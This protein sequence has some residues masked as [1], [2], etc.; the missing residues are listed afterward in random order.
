MKT[1]MWEKIIKMVTR[2]YAP[3]LIYSTLFVTFIVFLLIVIKID[4]YKIYECTTN[5]GGESFILSENVSIE[6][7]EYLCVYVNKSEEIIKINIDDI[8]ITN[9]TTLI[10]LGDDVKTF[11][12]KG[13]YTRCYIEVPVK[14]S[15]MRSI[16]TGRQ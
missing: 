5:D 3:F 10:F 6:E 15:I 4:S 9:D 13:G 2:S 7:A 1:N 8:L 14:S 11:L 12:N 16:F